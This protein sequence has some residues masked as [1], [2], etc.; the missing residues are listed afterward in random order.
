M[1]QGMLF[2]SLCARQPGVDVEQL[3]ITLPEALKTDPFERAWRWAAQRHA[4]LRTVFHWEE[5]DKT[6]QAVHA[7]GEPELFWQEWRSLVPAD[8]ERQW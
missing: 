7:D 5:T 2:H 3:L 4:I 1:Q 6:F 8:R